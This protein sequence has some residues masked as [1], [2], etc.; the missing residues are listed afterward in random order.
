M[1][2][3]TIKDY[4]DAIYQRFPTVNQKDIQRILNYGWKSLYLHNSYG[5][6]VCIKDND[7]WCYI[8]YLYKDSLK[9]FKIYVRKLCLKIRVLYNRKKLPFD[10]Y[11]YFSRTQNQVDKEYVIKKRGRKKKNFIFNNVKLYKIKDE[12]SVA[13]HGCQYIFRIQFPVFIGNT[14][15][16]K[17]LKTSEVE[18]IESRDPLKFKD[19]LV[20]NNNYE[21][22]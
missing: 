14:I 2:I 11:Y 1:K 13:E 5:G 16:K 17:E 6:D 3:T 4:Y 15:F 7:L 21:I 18:L 8:G 22:I 9:F 19:I 12:C 10:G 20:T